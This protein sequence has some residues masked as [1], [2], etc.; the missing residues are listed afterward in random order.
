MYT[1]E[2]MNRREMMRTALAGIGTIV[3]GQA[4]A[5]KCEAILTPTQ[6]SGP[7]YPKSR[8]HDQDADLVAV[9]G[10][11][12][13]AE[14]V[15]IFLSGVVLDQ[16]CNPVAGALVDLW[17]A[18]HSGKYNHPNDPNTAPLDANFQYS[19]KILTNEKGEFNLR[20]VI[21][22]A[23]PADTDWMRPPHIHI[24][25]AKLGYKELITQTYFD[26]FKELNDKD[27]ILKE[28]SAAEKENVIVKMRKI[29]PC[30]PNAPENTLGYVERAGNLTIVIKKM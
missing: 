21:P 5:E 28:L 11:T 10:H 19:A 9:E 12:N 29:N 24:R 6:T 23:Y 7:F 30:D 26:E 16:N 14:G 25:I 20:T 3:A 18:C 22:G 13:E 17:Q 15:K 8:L 27:L 2:N 1:G 4:L